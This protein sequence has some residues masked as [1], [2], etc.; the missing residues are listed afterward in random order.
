MR[1]CSLSLALCK[2]HPNYMMTDINWKFE[3][4]A[5]VHDINLQRNLKN[6]MVAYIRTRYYITLFFCGHCSPMWAMV[7]TFMR[8]LVHTQHTTVSMTP[9]DK[10]SAHRRDLYMTT[11]NTHK[12]QTFVP[13]LGF[14]PTNS[15][16]GWPHTYALDWVATGTAYY[17]IYS[18][19]IF[20]QPYNMFN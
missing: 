15:A 20:K 17:N 7:H 1:S 3:W 9:I 13:P 6:R 2:G 12:R 19:K 4:D 18:S 8:F 14:K 16:G 5:F 11:H 10:W